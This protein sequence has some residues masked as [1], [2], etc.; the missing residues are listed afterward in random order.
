MDRKPKGPPAVPPDSITAAGGCAT[1]QTK[2]ARRG[3]ERRR[4]LQRRA[5]AR[6]GKQPRRRG[7]RLRSRP[8]PQRQLQQ[9]A[10]PAAACCGS[11]QWTPSRQ[12]RAPTVSGTPKRRWTRRWNMR[13]RLCRC[14]WQQ[15]WLNRIRSCCNCRQ[16]R[17]N[18]CGRGCRVS[19]PHLA[20]SRLQQVMIYGGKEEDPI[21][22]HF[23]GRGA[24]AAYRCQLLAGCAADAAD[25]QRR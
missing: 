20:T 23:R 12:H 3:M 6:Q 22:Q 21:A 5:P 19:V 7:L 25:E 18:W 14:A 4:Q 13:R 9:V 1:S 24:R 17:S 11:W 2:T 15:T 16:H 10:R 8:A